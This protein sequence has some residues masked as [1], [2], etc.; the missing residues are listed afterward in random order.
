MTDMIDVIELTEE[1]YINQ[2]DLCIANKNL[3]QLKNKMT[4]F[5][6]YCFEEKHEELFPILLFEKI[7]SL[8]TDINFQQLNDTSDIIF[9]FEREW[10]KL[11]V[12][13]KTILLKA[14][15][16]TY[17][18]FADSLTHFILAELLGRFF[19]SNE[20]EAVL[21]ALSA[22]SNDEARAFIAMGYRKLFSHKKE[23][24]D[25]NK[26]LNKLRVM[27]KDK[28]ESVRTEAQTSINKIETATRR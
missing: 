20:S 13:Q 26:M 12:E 8:M 25:R 10:G 21:H 11:N 7:I 16:N 6:S 9:I 24:P 2:L 15:E 27:L 1:E 19:A 18:K 23:N 14:I 3:G 28:S 5:D 4:L 17:G 22:I